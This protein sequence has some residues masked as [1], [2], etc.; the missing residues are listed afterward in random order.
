MRALRL[1]VL[2]LIVG[3]PCTF[4]AP[5]S[6]QP[7]SSMTASPDTTVRLSLD[8]ALQAARSENYAVR[9]AEADRRRATAQKRQ[10]LGVFLPQVT[11]QEQAVATTDPVSA[12]GFTLKQERFTQQDFQVGALNDPDRVDNFRTSAQVQQPILNLD[13]LFQRRA[14][15]D[16]VRAARQAEARTQAVI[17]FRVKQ[18][19]FGLVLAERRLG[20]IDSALT[21]ARANRDQANALFEEGLITR[22]DLLAARVRVLELESQRT[23]A[24]AERRNA[25][26]RLNVLLGRDASARLVPTDSLTPAPVPTPSVD[27]DRVNR[28]RSDMQ[29]LRFRAEAARET[30]RGRWM[31]FVPTLNAQGTYEWND[32]TPLGTRGSGW[33]VGASLTWNLFEGYQQIGAA[34]EADAQVQ[35]ATVAL[36][37]Q[38]ARN[39]AAINEALRELQVRRQQVD[40]A[41]AA[42]EQADESLRIR[43]DRF[44]EGLARTTDVLQAEA[45]RAERR[46]A[47]VQALYR[48]NMAV[49]RLELLTERSLTD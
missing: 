17:T 9:A 2:L 19:Y 35:Q 29:A 31:A 26:D 16:G 40:Q 7:V 25:A 48:H 30:K 44:A 36:E 27:V 8:E 24:A 34:Q 47:L 22:A 46:L 10:T 41:R 39:R 11:L 13:G 45:Q 23:E 42:A 49:Y 37:E 3:L 21:A 1:V 18:G 38:A 43:T 20:V 6:A 28:T 4:G 33:T 15:S 12:F 14:A 32:D 5:A